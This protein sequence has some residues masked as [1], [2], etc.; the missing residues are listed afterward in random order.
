MAEPADACL[1]A[2]WYWHVNKL[3]VLADSAQWDAIT[4]AVNGPAMLQAAE[5]RQ[6]AQESV[7]VFA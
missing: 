2:A 3:N 1:T 5:R 7:G 6:Y 4:K